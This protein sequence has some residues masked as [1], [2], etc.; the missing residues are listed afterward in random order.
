MKKLLSILLS[1][2]LI[3]CLTACGG[4]E[5]E[6]KDAEPAVKVSEEKPAEKVEQPK[7]AKEESK[8]EEKAEEKKSE[9]APK[10]AEEKPEE[11]KKAEPKPLTL[12][13][14]KNGVY[15]NE[16]LGLGFKLPESSWKF[17]DNAELEKANGIPV[18]AT[19]DE[20][21]GAM[22]GSKALYAMMAQ[23][24][25][26]SVG[27]TFEYLN[28]EAMKLDDT[29]YMTAFMQRT[30]DALAQNG[31]ENVD[32]NVGSVKVGAKEYAAAQISSQAEDRQ[33]YQTL[34]C[35]RTGNTMMMVTLGVVGENSTAALLE[36]FY[37]LD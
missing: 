14:V 15:E 9:E 20:I 23:G 32:I 35:A 1:A 22:D 21:K 16:C 37:S 10:T 31:I 8:P 11:P 17:I 19:E 3:V 34:F 24:Q 33:I 26:G 2:G 12:G 27:I 28:D 30:Q 18:T 5:K 13:S 25:T 7:E 29:Q 36:N 6:V 4:E